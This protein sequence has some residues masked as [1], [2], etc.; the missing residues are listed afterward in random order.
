M[1]NTTEV[2]VQLRDLDQSLGFFD[3]SW[4][5]SDMVLLDHSSSMLVKVVT[6]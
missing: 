3:P 1:A 2:V 5:S 6:Q 4:V